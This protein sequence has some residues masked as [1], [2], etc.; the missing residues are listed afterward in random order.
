MTFSQRKRG[1]SSVLAEQGFF[2]RSKAVSNGS[3]KETRYLVGEI[4]YLSSKKVKPATTCLLE[5]SVALCL[6]GDR[7]Q[8]YASYSYFS[9]CTETKS[10]LRY[11]PKNH[12]Q[13][14]PPRECK[15]MSRIARR[16]I[17]SKNS[18]FLGLDAGCRFIRNC[19]YGNA[20]ERGGDLHG[21][22]D[23]KT[24]PQYTLVSNGHGV[25]EEYGRG[26]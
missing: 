4:L 3:N 11:H 15:A 5:L 26:V 13:L 17:E 2:C 19:L 23:S 20:S 6:R 12:T 14:R 24:P 22:G 16:G 10:T 8:W 1:G 9:A 18:R 25:S 7:R 21:D